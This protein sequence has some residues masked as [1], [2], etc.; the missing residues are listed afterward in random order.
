M[1]QGYDY[2]NCRSAWPVQ[3]TFYEFITI[4]YNAKYE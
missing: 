2:L 4:G 1:A 3:M